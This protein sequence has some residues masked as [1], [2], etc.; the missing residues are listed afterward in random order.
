MREPAS[1]G[2]RHVMAQAS[3]VPLDDEIGLVLASAPYSL[4]RAQMLCLARLATFSA[5]LLLT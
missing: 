2:E 1:G 3:A 5:L 4:A